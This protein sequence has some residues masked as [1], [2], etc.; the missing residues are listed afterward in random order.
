MTEDTRYAGLAIR[1]F[2]LT[3]DFLLFCAAF[4]PVTRIVTGVWL[5]SVNDHRWV[6]GWFVSDP[7]CVVFLVIIFAYFVCLEGRAGA[8]FGKWVLGVRVVRLDGGR[9]GLARSLARN[10]LRL[11]D[12]LPALNIVG[13][14]LILS[15][16]ERARVGDRWAGTRVVHVA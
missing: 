1:F 13:V 8:T 11:V 12:G 16:P 4:F 7:V 10:L 2:A 9:P 14:V 3:V 5:M 6:H 15:S